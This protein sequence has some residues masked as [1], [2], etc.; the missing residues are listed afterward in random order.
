MFL[1]RK[2]LKNVSFYFF[3]HRLIFTILW[4]NTVLS[5][6]IQSLLLKFGNYGSELMRIKHNWLIRLLGYGINHLHLG[7]LYN[8]VTICKVFL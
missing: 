6:Y 3:F 8:L 2:Y 4:E 5:V 7:N 1:G